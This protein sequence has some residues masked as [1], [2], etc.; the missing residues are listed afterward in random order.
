ML[1]D[2][3]AAAFNIDDAV[4]IDFWTDIVIPFSDIGQRSIDICLCQSLGGLLDPFNFA[5]D[6]VADHGKQIVFQR[7]ELFLRTENHIFQFF[8]FRGNIPLCI[9]HRLFPGPCFRHQIFIGVGHLQIVAE[10]FIVFNAEIFNAGILPFGLFHLSQPLL[11]L[12]FCMA[13]LVDRFMVS[14]F[15]NTTLFNRNRRFIFNGF[16]NGFRNIFQRIHGFIDFL[17]VRGCHI[18]EQIPDRRNHGKGI[19]KGDQIPWVCGFVTDFTHQT[20]KVIDGI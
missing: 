3:M 1:D 10:N 11:A 14:G 12:G 20:F 5:A 2:R 9:G 17:H 7:K 16:F 13:V 19:F 15:Y 4:F 18:P 8:K 6:L